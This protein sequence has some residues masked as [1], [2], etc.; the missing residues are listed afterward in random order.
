[1]ILI[2]R[3]DSFKAR[4]IDETISG[5]SGYRPGEALQDTTV[6]ARDLSHR[7]A[8]SKIGKSSERGQA[9]RPAR[10]TAI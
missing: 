6:Q 3:A 4:Y 10:V 8:L 9:A 7:P 2:V 5:Q 1:M